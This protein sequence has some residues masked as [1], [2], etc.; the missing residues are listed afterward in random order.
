MVVT[1]TGDVGE[2][3]GVAIVE[4]IASPQFKLG[5]SILFDARLSIDNPTSEDLRSSARWLSKL[6]PMGISSRCAIVVGP[7]PHQYGLAR[8]AATHLECQGMCLEIFL[9]IGEAE[10]W[11]SITA[12]QGRLLAE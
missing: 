5:T 4:A 3:A 11:L 10:R 7:K 1:C 8:M 9:D 6:Q 12:D 2:G